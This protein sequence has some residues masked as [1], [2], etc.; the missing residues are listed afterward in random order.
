MKR[1]LVLLVGINILFFISCDGDNMTEPTEDTEPPTVSITSPSGGSTVSGE[2]DIS[3]NATD[4]EQVDSVQVFLDNTRVGSANGEPFEVTIESLVFADSADHDLTAKAFDS[5]QNS[6]TSEPVSV[7]IVA[8]E[9]SLSNDLQPVF[10]SNCVGCHGG[11]SGNG[12]LELDNAYSE[13]VNT[14]SQNYGPL[15]RVRPFKP[16]S[17][18]LY[19]KIIENPSTDVGTRMPANGPYLSQYHQSLVKFWIEQGAGD[20]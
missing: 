19:L 1:L 5:S 7:T 8:F 18:V 6:A 13:L 14:T 3:V 15:N 20:N 16:D 4:N 9:I 10:D 17:S 11:D 12:G 2:V